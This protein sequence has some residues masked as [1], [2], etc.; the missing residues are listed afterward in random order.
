MAG[1]LT[2]PLVA[3]DKFTKWI[4]TKTL[5]IIGSKQAMDLILDMILSS[6]EKDS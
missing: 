2:H 1:G 6:P 5:A 3:V 4:E